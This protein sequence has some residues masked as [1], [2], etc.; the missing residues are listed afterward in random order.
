MHNHCLSPPKE[1]INLICQIWI[2]LFL[3][4]F[5]CRLNCILCLSITLPYPLWWNCFQRYMWGVFFYTQHLVC[6]V[7]FIKAGR[8]I[9]IPETIK[10]K[11]KFKGY[12]MKILFPVTSD[13]EI[14]MNFTTA[15]KQEHNWFWKLISY[16]AWNPHQGHHDLS[17][18]TL[19]HYFINLN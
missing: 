9:R 3:S 13:S 10:K 15:C 8:R 6:N 14:L 7:A 12:R 17:S 2:F 18:P 4:N 19:I 16:F 11:S 5:S 1:K